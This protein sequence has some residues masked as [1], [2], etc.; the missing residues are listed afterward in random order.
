MSRYII[1]RLLM[2]VPALLGVSLFVFLVL[3]KFTSDPP[4]LIPDQHATN[5]HMQA[6]REEP[7]LRAPLYVQFGVYLWQLSHGDLGRS[8]MTGAPVTSE[9]LA[10]FPATIELAFAALLIATLVGVTAGVI[11]AVKKH[12]IFDYLSV[13]GARI[14]VSMPIFWLGLMLIILFSVK[15]DWLPGAGRIDMGLE[16]AGIT[17]L[18]LVDSAL[19]GNWDAF[20]SALYH[21]ILPAVALASYSMAVIARMTRTTTLEAVRQDHVRTAR[22]KGL[23]EFMVICRHVLPNAMIPVVKVIGRQTGFLLG[24]AVLIETVFAWPGIGGMLV[25]AIQAADYP[26]VRGCVLLIVTV[27]VVV[28]LMVDLLYVWLDPRIRHPRGQINNIE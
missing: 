8:L 17:G 16:P 9:M 15:L 26:L 28:K 7:G 1:K 23:G 25:K 4:A 3:H 2:L 20:T 5:Q 24:G 19:T 21:L 13:Y 10:G 22:A 11:S 12:S 14:G 27:F 18:Y 6:L